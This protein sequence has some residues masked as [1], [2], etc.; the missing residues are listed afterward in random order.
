MKK[1]Y[2]T[3]KTIENICLTHDRIVTT[4]VFYNLRVKTFEIGTQ[5][6]RPGRRN[7]PYMYNIDLSIIQRGKPLCVIFIQIRIFWR[8]VHEPMLY[9]ENLNSLLVHYFF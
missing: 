7:N 5:N 6:R 9:D 4:K 2:K 3:D 8:V 1:V